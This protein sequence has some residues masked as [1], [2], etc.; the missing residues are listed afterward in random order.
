MIRRPN[1]LYAI[2]KDLLTNKL[3]P[4]VSTV[5]RPVD[6]TA[7]EGA[8][9]VG[10]GGIVIDPTAARLY[11]NV[12]TLASPL[13][14]AL[15][16]EEFVDVSLTSAVVK[17]IRATPATL[18]AAPGAGKALIYLGAMFFLDY[19]GTNVFTESTANMT[20][21]YNS[22]AGAAA[23]F[24]I[25]NTGFIDQAADM[26]TFNAPLTGGAAALGNIILAKAAIENLPL[27]LH[28]IG[29]GE[30][31]GNAGADNVLRIRVFFATVRTGF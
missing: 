13:F 3:G 20:V 6:G 26:V 27:V 12:G 9:I 10:P 18:V 5:G 30:I 4:F 24:S 7:G 2:A 14:E 31:A 8:L 19:G 25:E 29:A 28:N 23:G 17:A 22:G 21:K 15:S 11:Q 16:G 1:N